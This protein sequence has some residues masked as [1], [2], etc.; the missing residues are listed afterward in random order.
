MTIFWGCFHWSL[1][2]KFLSKSHKNLI[3]LINVIGKLNIKTISKEEVAVSDH[4]LEAFGTTSD[5][6]KVPILPPNFFYQHN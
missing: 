4:I 3:S 2:K 6:K 5:E 1:F